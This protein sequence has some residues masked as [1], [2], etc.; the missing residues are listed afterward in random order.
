MKRAKV[1]G[2]ISIKGGVGKTTTVA[3]LGIILAR[4]FK[5]RVLIV[6]GNFS[7][8]NLALHF[9][10]SKMGHTLHDVLEGKAKL[11][12]AIYEHSSGLHLLPASVY[13]R[14]VDYN[15]FKNYIS[16]LRPFYDL[17]LIDSS[18]SLN[19]EMLAAIMAA[20]ELFVI[21]TP[22]YVTLASTLNAVKTARQKRT[23]IAGIIM[24]KVKGKKYELK[25]EDIQDATKVPVVSIL[26]DDEELLKAL[27]E[28]D[29]NASYVGE[30]GIGC[31]P[32]IIRY[33]NNLLFDE[34][35]NLTIHSLV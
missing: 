2:F 15:K 11:H 5:K 33:S 7:G 30:L 3:N 27:L 9:G 21:T 35:I 13:S 23:Y 25:M 17:I 24:N 14:K 22:D 16:S 20:D 26:K 28:T 31:N 1:V 32:K 10:F 8:P 29:E 19:D 12:K 34:K 18:P 4:D 6:D